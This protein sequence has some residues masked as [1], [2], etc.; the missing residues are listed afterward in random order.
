MLQKKESL[1][2]VREDAGYVGVS[3]RTYAGMDLVCVED[4]LEMKQK[5]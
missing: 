5:I 4:V 3:G 1:E 2:L